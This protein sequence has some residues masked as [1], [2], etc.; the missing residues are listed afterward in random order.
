MGFSAKQL[1]RKEEKNMATRSSNIRAIDYEKKGKVLI[2]TFLTGARYKYVGVS[3]D[4]ADKFRAAPSWGKFF[5]RFIR[6]SFPGAQ[7]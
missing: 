2:I 4:L 7:A 3:E 6:G 5:H 1:K